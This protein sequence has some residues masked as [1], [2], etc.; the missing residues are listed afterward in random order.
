MKYGKPLLQ[1]LEDVIGAS[2]IALDK[3]EGDYSITVKPLSV[4]FVTSLLDSEIGT[5]NY[6]M[7]Y[8]AEY[9][10]WTIDFNIAGKRRQVAK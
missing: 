3:E 6:E 7:K 9:V 8:N 1:R 10:T 4:Q 5:R 2:I